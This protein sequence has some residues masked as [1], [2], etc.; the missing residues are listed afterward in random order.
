MKTYFKLK[1]YYFNHFPM[2]TDQWFLVHWEDF[3]K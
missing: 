3:V 1:T 2:Q